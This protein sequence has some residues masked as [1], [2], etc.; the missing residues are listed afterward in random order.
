MLSVSISWS[1]TSFLSWY[2]RSSSTAYTFKP[3]LVLVEAIR[4]TITSELV[5]GLPCPVDTDKREQF[6]LDWVPFTGTGRKVADGGFK[7]GL[8]GG[9]LEVFLPELQPVPVRSSRVRRNHQSR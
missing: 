9:S 3:E 7:A 2:V 1:K 4:L 6:V 5:R 8:V